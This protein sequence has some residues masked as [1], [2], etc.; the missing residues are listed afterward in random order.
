MNRSKRTITAANNLLKNLSYI[1]DYGVFIW[2]T[3]ACYNVKSGRL[4]GTVTKTGYVII[5]H[6][7]VRFLAHRLVWFYENKKWPD[8]MLDHINGIKSDNRIDNLRESSARMNGQNRIEHRLGKRVGTRNPIKTG[9]KY[10]AFININKKIIN[11]GYYN[12][13]EMAEIVYFEACNLIEK[14]NDKNP[15]EFIKII[16][17][18]LEK[19]GINVN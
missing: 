14:F 12:S 19:R 16:K 18:S 2:K 4:A 10:C 7:G 13:D 17:K 8:S 3:N 5:T 6:L 9:G 1:K 11:L 15:K